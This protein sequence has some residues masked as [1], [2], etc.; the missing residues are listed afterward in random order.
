MHE[1]YKEHYVYELSNRNINCVEQIGSAVVFDL[2]RRSTTIECEN[3][4][5]AKVVYNDVCER[6]LSDANFMMVK[7]FLVNL[8]NVNEV[9]I[10]ENKIIV[11]YDSSATYVLCE[12]KEEAEIL[13]KEIKNRLEMFK[14][15]NCN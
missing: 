2:I 10:N 1:L 3:L 13:Y 15:L 14:Q 8:E 7:K 6:L 4:I 5:T 9:K 11:H 12:N